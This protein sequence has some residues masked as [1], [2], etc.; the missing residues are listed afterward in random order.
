M[1]YNTDVNQSGSVSVDTNP[2]VL[3]E[4][5]RSYVTLARTLNLSQTAEELGVTRQTVRRHID[6]LEQIK[7]VKL[8][9]VLDRQYAVTEAG[10]RSLAD[11]SLLLTRASA[12]LNGEAAVIGGLAY[13]QYNVDPKH[14]SYAQQHP[15]NQ[16]WATGVPLLQKGLQMWSASESQLEHRAMRKLRPYLV[17]Y[18]RL[19]NDWLCVSIGEKS[20][21]ARWLGWAWAKS[22]IGSALQEDEMNTPSDRFVMDAYN[23][24]HQNGSVRYDHV[25]TQLPK[26]RDGPLNPVTYQRMV[27][28]CVFPDG[29]PAIAVLLA[30]TDQINIEGFEIAS[31]TPTAKADLMEFEI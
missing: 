15:I 1:G 22:A 19:R 25:Y 10:T 28:A 6:T 2:P 11:A 4:M 26:R 23:W 20:A 9:E 17:V 16:V 31:V 18:R 7:G 3:F 5:L 13:L 12:W 8:F 24:V 14:P 21:Y 29:Q 30:R 27:F